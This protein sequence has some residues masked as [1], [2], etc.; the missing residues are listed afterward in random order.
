LTT[1]P[2]FAAA[3]ATQMVLYVLRVW[4]YLHTDRFPLDTRQ[5]AALLPEGHVTVTGFMSGFLVGFLVF[6]VRGLF[7]ASAK[8]KSASVSTADT[9]F[10]L[11]VVGCG[12]CVSGSEVILKLENMQSEVVRTKVCHQVKNV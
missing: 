9:S 12:G 4:S 3:A 10:M 5:S 2:V 11:V 7:W 6:F 1:A 8:G